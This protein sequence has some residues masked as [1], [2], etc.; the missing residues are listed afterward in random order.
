[1]VGVRRAGASETARHLVPKP[2]AGFRMSS[3]GIAPPN[4]KNYSPLFAC[5]SMLVPN[6]SN[7]HFS[8]RV[9]TY[10]PASSWERAQPFLSRR[11]TAPG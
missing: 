5:S 6:K 3:W 7:D 11:G 8:W 9:D 1:M 10:R 4:H 2:S